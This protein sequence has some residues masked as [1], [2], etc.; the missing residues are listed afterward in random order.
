VKRHVRIYVRYPPRPGG[1]ACLGYLYEDP[2]AVIAQLSGASLWR[3]D[4]GIGEYAWTDLLID[5][6]P[7]P[8][9]ATVVRVRPVD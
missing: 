5:A 7:R 8:G 1:V 6:P 3:I 2:D 9:R 4:G